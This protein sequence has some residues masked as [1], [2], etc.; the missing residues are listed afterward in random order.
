MTAVR[1]FHVQGAELLCSLL[2]SGNTKISV[3]LRA[4]ERRKTQQ[5]LR[6]ET[7]YAMRPKRHTDAENSITKATGCAHVLILLTSKNVLR[8]EKWQQK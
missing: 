7:V 5:T 1:R 3:V 8:A 2:L 6:R 4:K